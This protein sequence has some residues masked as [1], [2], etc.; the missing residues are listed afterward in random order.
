MSS[1]GKSQLINM[2][3]LPLQI[4]GI[5]MPERSDFLCHEVEKMLKSIWCPCNFRIHAQNVSPALLLYLSIRDWMYVKSEI[6][7]F[8]C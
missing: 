7:R 5:C 6:H 4:H 3:H 8:N 2:F 1:A